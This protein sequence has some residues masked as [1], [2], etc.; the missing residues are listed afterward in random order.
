MSVISNATLSSIPNDT[1]P[2]QPHYDSSCIFVES[3][4]EK[5]SK[6]LVYCLLLLGSFLGNIFIIIIFYKHRDLHKT[7]NY[8]IVNMALS[9]LV[10]PLALF[11]IQITAEATASSRWHIDGIVGSIVCKFLFFT[12]QVSLLVSTQSLVWIA[13][14]RFVAVVFP[15]RLGLISTKVRIMAIA[16]TWIL[17]AAFNSPH[18]ITWGLFT[19]GNNTFCGAVNMNSVFTNQEASAAYFWLQLIFFLIAPL[20][21]VTF[22][23][24]VVAVALKRQSKTNDK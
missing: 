6:L 2:S 22:L 19:Q 1:A 18:L 23:Y 12:S 11:P 8:F 16:S 3:A 10:F 20:F 17:A 14:D 21:L 5:M 4:A 24:V 15:I 9:D 7:V 13:I